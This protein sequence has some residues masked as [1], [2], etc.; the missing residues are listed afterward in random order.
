MR[1]V[2]NKPCNMGGKRYFIGEEIPPDEILDPAALEKMG[3]IHVIHD[4]IRK[5]SNGR[6]E[7]MP[8][9]T[10]SIQI[11]KEDGMFEIG[12]TEAQIREVIKTM[13]MGTR[14]AVAHIRDAVTDDTVL[15]ILDAA[16]SRVQI[17]KEAEAKAKEIAGAEESKGDA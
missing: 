1:F 4:G 12:V 14:D 9:V 11:M 13:Q 7:G 10:F 6:E 2:A 3:I 16:D 15:I 8:E 17:K 5:E